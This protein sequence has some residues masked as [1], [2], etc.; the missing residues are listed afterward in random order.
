MPFAFKCTLTL[1]NKFSE[2]LLTSFIPMMRY[3]VADLLNSANAT[4]L[5]L[6]VWGYHS[7]FMQPNPAYE[8]MHCNLSARHIISTDALA[9]HIDNA[10][11]IHL[12]FSGTFKHLLKPLFLQN[13]DHCK[14][15][16]SNEKNMNRNFFNMEEIEKHV[17]PPLSP[18]QPS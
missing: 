9:H 7:L 5:C 12:I 17:N 2:K 1:R 14:K 3:V 8:S 11:W 6:V 16:L 4:G 13:C 18:L 10:E 15:A